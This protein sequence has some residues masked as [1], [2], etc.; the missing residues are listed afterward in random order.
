MRDERAGDVG[1]LYQDEKV[2]LID[3]SP[4]SGILVEW[5]EPNGKPSGDRWIMWQDIDISRFEEVK[6]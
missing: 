1:L 4:S 6:I 2:L 3:L 5:E